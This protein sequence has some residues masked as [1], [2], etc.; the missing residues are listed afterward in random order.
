[1]ASGRAAAKL[2]SLERQMEEA[3]SYD[4]WAKLAKQ[5]DELSGMAEWKA[6][7]RSSHYDYTEIGSRLGKLRRLLARNDVRGLLFTSTRASTAIWAAW[8]GRCFI[9]G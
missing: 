3:A 9:R 2:R 5:H 1:M 4:Q 6:T 8:A 7:E